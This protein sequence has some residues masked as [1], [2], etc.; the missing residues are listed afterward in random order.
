MSKTGDIVLYV[1]LDAA[2]LLIIIFMILLLLF[3]ARRT[4]VCELR[5]ARTRDVESRTPQS[6]PGEQFPTGRPIHSDI[7]LVPQQSARV[8]TKAPISHNPYDSRY[9]Y[10]CDCS[11]T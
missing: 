7:P 2:I 11:N 5:T 6:L 1:L 9:T 10:A 3:E 4:R 8:V